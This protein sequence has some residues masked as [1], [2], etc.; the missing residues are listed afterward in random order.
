MNPA[1]IIIAYNRPNALKR[2]LH[3]ISKAI[4]T[5][6]DIPLCVC[7]DYIDTKENRTVAQI[8]DD[9]EWKYGKKE[10]I[11]QQSNLGLKAHVL[12]SCNLVHQYDSIIVLEDD[13]YVSPYFYEYAVSALSFYQEETSIAG[14]SLYDY[15]TI[16]HNFFPF[17]PLLDNSDVYFLQFASSWGQ[18][19]SKKQ[20]VDFTD[21]FSDNSVI[22]PEI[23]LPDYVLG[24]P[25]SSWKKHFIHYLFR[26]HKY[27][28]YPRGSY[29]TNFND[30]GINNQNYNPFFQVP[31]QIHDKKVNLVKIENSKSI[32]DAFFEINPVIIKHYNSSLKD[33]NFEMD[34]HGLKKLEKI[35]AKFLITSKMGKS[36]LYTYG[37]QLKPIELNITQALVGN[38]FRL[39]EKKTLINNSKISYQQQI[40]RLE[41]FFGLIPYRRYYYIFFKF[42]YF[43]KN[44]LK[45]NRY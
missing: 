34:L 22:N 33:Y 11:K 39:E 35:S 7:I 24:W 2:L 36:P 1:I 23:H 29:T 13:L 8:A 18:A 40:Y 16:E 26:N 6:I 30:Q 38:Y 21:W 44:I 5:N 43:L 17:I 20:W 37:L 28:V 42:A 41:Y 32:Y 45:N 10:I 9:F 27:F 12:K 14:I 19:F 15:H 4:Y 31:M 3:S 25:E